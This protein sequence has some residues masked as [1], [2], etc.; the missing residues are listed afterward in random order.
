[1]AG[2]VHWRPFD[3]M[4]TPVK[5][6]WFARLSDEAAVP[7]MALAL[8]MPLVLQ[9]PTRHRDF[10]A[11]DQRAAAFDLTGFDRLLAK[12]G[13]GGHRGKGRLTYRPEWTWSL[14]R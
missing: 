5:R 4:H 7:A 8:A 2:F 10:D 14:H 1:M 9:D 12:N 11:A 13:P 3:R 6:T